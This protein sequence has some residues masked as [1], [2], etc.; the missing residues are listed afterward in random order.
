MYWIVLFLALEGEYGTIVN[1]HWLEPVA[2]TLEQCNAIVESTY[3]LTA[4]STKLEGRM[5]CKYRDSIVPGS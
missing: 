5:I 4:T 3:F 2:H 1:E